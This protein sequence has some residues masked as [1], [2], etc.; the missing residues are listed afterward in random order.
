MNTNNHQWILTGPVKHVLLR[1]SYPMLGA[2]FLLFAYDVL[3]AQLLSQISLE[4]ITALG[5]TI[6]VTT[7][8]AAFAIAMTITT[9]TS[10]T[11]AI[12]KHQHRAEP[13]IINSLVVAI[14]TSIIF[15]T[16]GY[17]FNQTIFE[18]LGINYA[19]LPDSYHQGPRPQLMPLIENY[20]TW[21]YVGL[22][23]L[24]LIWQIN[25]LLRAVGLTNY[26]GTTF[27]LWMLCKI[28]LA[29]ALFNGL[30]P[31][32]TCPLETAALIHIIC[33][34]LFAIIGLYLLCKKLDI[35]R[36]THVK[37][38]PI[39][40]FRRLAVVGV[41]ATMQQILTPLSITL[42]TIMVVS[43]G[44]V[45]VA[46]L[47]IVFRLEML[48]LLVPMVLTTALPSIV[49][50]NWWSGQY[51]RVRLFMRHAKNAVI[52]SQLIVTL[53]LYVYAPNIAAWFATDNTI[54][55]NIVIYLQ[56][57]PI[58]FIAAGIT[59]ISQSSLNAS[60][61]YGKASL[62]SVFHRIIFKMSCCYI[63]LTL[64][65]I[66]GLFIGIIS[67]HILSALL[68]LVL[69]KVFTT[70]AQQQTLAEQSAQQ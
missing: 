50:V 60:G 63:G 23:F 42:L 19:M 67:A 9:N 13:L 3:E 11:K 8:M 16:L 52:V 36:F 26:A 6:P 38:E 4:A 68:T 64:A 29:L 61:H 17:A 10:V 31:R 30:L 5:F 48:L 69:S 24:V 20:M 62:I 59:I 14:L 40:T 45:Y 43:Y 46:L 25:S 44:Q 54:A 22:V 56:L 34:A 1:V 2:I 33:D 21:R 57:V 66:Q 47:G 70:K 51:L 7:A 15:A 37:I 28:L 55:D 32:P 18:F 58:S 41:P 65:G 49:G 39:K 27:V 53:I 12:S 35:K